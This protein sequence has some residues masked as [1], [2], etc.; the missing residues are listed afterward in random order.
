MNLALLYQS[1]V[2]VVDIVNV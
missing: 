2:S 1:Y